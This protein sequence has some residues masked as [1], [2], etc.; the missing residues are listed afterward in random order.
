MKWSAVAIVLALGL[1]SCT[2]FA[3]PI[4]DYTDPAT[5]VDM[6][7][8]GQAPPPPAA[9]QPMLAYEYDYG[10]TV[11]AGSL[12]ALMAGHERA[13]REA[14]P[15]VCQLTASSIRESDNS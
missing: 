12:R 2:K 8:P 4:G 3:L 14:G 6:V 5:T 13:C 15:A 9:G 7:K 1:A 10:L 11:P